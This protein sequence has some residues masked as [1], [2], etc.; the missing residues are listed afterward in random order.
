MIVSY[1]FGLGHR[2][3]D[4][5]CCQTDELWGQASNKARSLFWGNL[6]NNH[7]GN[8]DFADSVWVYCL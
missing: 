5:G 6:S 3:R 2:D 8:I 7:R 4:W 1:F